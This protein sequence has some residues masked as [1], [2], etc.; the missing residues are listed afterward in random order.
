MK[1][2]I[3]KKAKEYDIVP[4]QLYSL[5]GLEQLLM[6][7]SKSMYRDHFVVKGGYLLTS[8]YGLDNRSTNDLDGTIRNM[9]LTHESVSKFVTFIESP[10]ED[11][12]RYFEVKQVRPIREAF[13]YD[14]F[15]IKMNFLNGKSRYSIELDLT[16]GEMLLPTVVNQ[17]IKMMF[18]DGEINMPT[19]PIEQILA[20][21]IYT[22]LA[23]GV[24]DDTNSR[25]K[26]LYDIYFLTKTNKEIDYQMVNRAIKNIMYQRKEK[27]YLDQYIKIID[28]LWLSDL[29]RE[30]WLN[31]TRGKV[32]AK[33]LLFDTIMVSVKEFVN[34]LIK[35]QI[36]DDN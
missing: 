25:S 35:S 17:N 23:Y 11:G 18:E 32:F 2:L 36:R 4:L 1:R 24:I 33:D 19:Y 31:Y 13:D 15:N 16:T 3:N 20:D 34:C 29:Q 6:K 28:F 9:S 30:L 5:Y 14:G 8:I 27:I 7:I 22:T 12:N 26:D 21:K 10:S